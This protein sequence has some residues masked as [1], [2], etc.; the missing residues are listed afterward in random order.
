MLIAIDGPVAVGKSTVGR[1][2]AKR[3]N[4]PFLDTGLMYRAV[5][6]K[7][8]KKGIEPSDEGKIEDL[9]KKLEIKF[10]FSTNK[11]ESN[12]EVDGKELGHEVRSPEVEKAV[13][14]VSRIPRVREFLV[15]R[16]RKISRALPNLVMAG[17]D[18]G[19]V[20]LPGAKYKYFLTAS[21]EIRAERRFKEL[22]ARGEKRDYLSILKEIKERDELDTHRSISPLKPAKDAIMIDT[23]NLSIEQVTEAI[24]NKINS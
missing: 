5:T 3:L 7:V 21:P 4:Y 22:K 16:Q 6:W 8:L 17:R 12:L 18:I 11:D 10:N 19:T 20:V 1:A 15:S 14:L 24:L 13:S 9:I 23:E 2:I